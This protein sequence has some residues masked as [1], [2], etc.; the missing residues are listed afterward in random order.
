[1]STAGSN[2]P[3]FRAVQLDFTGHLRN[4]Q[5]NPAPAGADPQRMQIYVE[6]VF[7]NI[8]GLLS[9]SFP[10]AKQVLGTQR[11]HDLVRRF[12]HLHPSE[13]PFFLEISQEFLTFIDAHPDPA[14][15]DFL[16]E[17]CHY[18]WVE[19]AL[20][21]EVSDLP[22]SG[23]DRDGSLLGNVMVSPLIWRLAY[24]YAVHHIGPDNQPA[25]PPAQPTYLVVYRRADDSVRFMESNPLTHRLLELIESKSGRDALATLADELPDVAPATVLEQGEEALE[26][27]RQCGIILGA[28]L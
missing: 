14:L 1:M 25:E 17:L 7:N 15:P 24:R 13:S 9:S 12:L 4:P 26:R 2:L 11:W 27:M 6:L 28:A 19:M 16:L 3:A 5:T 20:D 21:V 8:Q 22:D 23:F 18:E 10:I